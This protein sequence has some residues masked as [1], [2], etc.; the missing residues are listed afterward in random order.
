VS[1]SD[2]KIG[3]ADRPLSMHHLVAPEIAC[4][5][6]VRLA[7]ENGCR[8]VCL[9]TQMPS[10]AG[11]P[12]I[13]DSDIDRVRA[14]LDASG[15]GVLG[16]TS[17][18]LGATPWQDYLPGLQRSAKLGARWVNCRVESDDLAALVA[19]FRGVAHAA[20]DLGMRAGIEFSGFA[21]VS[22]LPQ[23]LQVIEQAGIGQLSVD[24]LHVT[25]TNTSLTNLAQ[26]D[27]GLIGYVQINDGLREA[28]PES[29]LHEGAYDRLFPG[30]GTFPL[31]EL[32]ELVPEDLALS[33]EVPTR[34]LRE[35][36]VSAGERIRCVVGASR[37]L[38]AALGAPEAPFVTGQKCS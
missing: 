6:L 14:A 34:T 17:F 22:A 38:L 26:L 30:E 5:E 13:R 12:V 2:N 31:K 18:G 4:E 25:R 32:L 21:D 37:A 33:L 19:N 29:Y 9:F 20:A 27:P 7:A 28:T 35:Q 24:A 23:A 15:V 3:I 8:H 10:M 16:V 1:R 11:F 36:G